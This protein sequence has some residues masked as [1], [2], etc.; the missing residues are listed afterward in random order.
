MNKISLD[1]ILLCIDNSGASASA[2]FLGFTHYCDR[3]RKGGF[4]DISPDIYS[5]KV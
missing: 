4:K 5:V 3:T 2:D 1:K